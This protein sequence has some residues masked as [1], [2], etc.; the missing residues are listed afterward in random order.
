MTTVREEPMERDQPPISITG[1][2][3]SWGAIF[4]GFVTA[5]AIQICLGLLGIGLGLS[6][7]STVGMI[8]AIL[9]ILLALFIG[10]MVTGRLAGILRNKEGFL[11]G[12][13]LWGLTTL[14]TVWM[15]WTGASFLLGQ[16][17]NL[18]GQTASAAVTGVTNVGAS[19][20]GAGIGQVGNVDVAALRSEIEQALRQTGDPALQPE[21]LQAAANRVA[22]RATSSPAGNQDLLSALG[23]VVANRAAAVD[24]E[25]IINVVVARTELSRPEAERVA[26]RVISAATT[27]QRQVSSIWRGLSAEASGIASEAAGAIQTAAWVALAMLVL[28]A[29]TGIA[30]T[31]V[32]ARS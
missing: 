22:N 1:F 10:G 4:G 30:G 21:S 7:T 14:V 23:N 25:D 16:T 6:V 15:A 26:D 17:I 29:A 31:M 11:H 13:V 32:T 20:V 18:V 2:R 5:V 19:A 8:W 12:T 27:V 9:S 24:R 28:S 3:L